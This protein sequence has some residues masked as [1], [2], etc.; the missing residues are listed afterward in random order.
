ML[1]FFVYFG[2]FQIYTCN[3]TLNDD[4]EQ[5]QKKH[6]F[7]EC[8]DL[9]NLYILQHIITDMITCD[10]MSVIRLGKYMPYW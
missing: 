8:L 1:D 4:M 7:S 2:H 6:G 3:S 5:E 9:K 10:H